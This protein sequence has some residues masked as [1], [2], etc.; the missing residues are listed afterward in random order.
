MAQN[1]AEMGLAEDP[2]KAIPIP[3]KLLVRKG[4]A[5]T[6]P[7]WGRYPRS[8][9]QVA[10][11]KSLAVDT[12]LILIYTLI[13]PRS[14]R[15]NELQLFGD[16]MDFRTNI[17]KPQSISWDLPETGGA[18]NAA[19]KLLLITKKGSLCT[20]VPAWPICMR[21]TFSGERW[22]H[23]SQGKSRNDVVCHL[24]P[25]TQRFSAVSLAHKPV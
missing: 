15:G 13:L 20:A 14:W 12:F 11:D 4:L 1:L 5:G 7:L 25:F 9:G 2:N 24:S 3:K 16:I 6:A 18:G 17:K 22:P 19:A 10:L 21:A 8:T 23:E